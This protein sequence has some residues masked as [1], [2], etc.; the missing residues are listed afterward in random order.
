MHQTEEFKV[1]FNLI[2]INNATKGSKIDIFNV[3]RTSR[4]K[5]QTEEM[6]ISFYYVVHYIE[7]DDRLR[8]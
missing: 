1:E 8:K 7:I 5:I 2:R 4:K 6:F 3:L